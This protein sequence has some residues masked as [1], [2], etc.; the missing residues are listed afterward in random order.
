[1]DH[2]HD[3]KTIKADGFVALLIWLMVHV[4]LYKVLGTAACQ[5]NEWSNMSNLVLPRELSNA[6]LCISSSAWQTLLHLA[7]R[8]IA[9]RG[10]LSLWSHPGEFY[11]AVTLLSAIAWLLAC[12]AAAASLARTRNAPLPVFS[13]YMRGGRLAMI[14]LTK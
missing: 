11:V 4:H 10:V 6:Y 9:W 7:P 5:P 8:P 13:L 2:S 14:C 1:M 12:A 3:W